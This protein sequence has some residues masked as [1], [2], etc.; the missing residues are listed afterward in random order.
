M[1]TFFIDLSLSL[2]VLYVQ[3]TIDADPE[4]FIDPN[5]WSKDGTISLGQCSFS[6][7]GSYCAHTVSESGSDWTTVRVSTGP[8]REGER[9]KRK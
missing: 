1:L 7:D 2:S 3:E 6:E 9:G 5:D 8:K 4:V